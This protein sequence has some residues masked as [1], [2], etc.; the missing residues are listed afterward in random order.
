MGYQR[1]VHG[2]MCFVKL[3]DILKQLPQKHN[4]TFCITVYQW[5]SILNISNKRQHLLNPL[6]YCKKITQLSK[7]TDMVKPFIFSY[8]DHSLTVSLDKSKHF[9]VF[10]QL[11]IT[12]VKITSK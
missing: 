2:P 3:T 8:V 5:S 12:R 1:R 11:I 7:I 9:K 10:Y 6:T 4:V